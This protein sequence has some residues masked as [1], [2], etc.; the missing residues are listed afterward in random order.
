NDRIATRDKV[1]KWCPG[2]DTSCPLCGSYEETREHI[3]AECDYAALIFREHLQELLGCSWDGIVA[4]AKTWT[5]MNPE[6]KV[7]RLCWRVV[8]SMVWIERCKRVFTGVAM[9]AVEETD[10]D[11]R[12][13]R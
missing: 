5:L 13:G 12:D 4:K 11:C 10:D 8:V 9:Q 6:Q 3:Y 2:I 1:K 7:K